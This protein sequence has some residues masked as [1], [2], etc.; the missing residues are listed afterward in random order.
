MPNQVSP[1]AKYLVRQITGLLILGFG[2][3]SIIAGVE[4]TDELT[5]LA[6]IAY[7]AQQATDGFLTRRVINNGSK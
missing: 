4:F 7:G 6:V 2:M 1:T 5:K 3:Y